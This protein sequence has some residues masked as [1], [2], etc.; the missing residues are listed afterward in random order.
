[1]SLLA[2]PYFSLINVSY[3][4]TYLLYFCNLVCKNI[5]SIII[6]FS[7]AQVWIS[8]KRQ[9]KIWERWHCPSWHLCCPS[10]FAPSCHS[11]CPT[12]ISSFILFPLIQ[13]L[14]F[15]NSIKQ[16]C[17]LN[18]FILCLKQIERTENSVKILNFYILLNKVLNSH[19]SEA[20]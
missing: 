17:I 13:Y 5:E 8:M 9:I 20:V 6:Y 1:M 19:C 3:S 18:I 15:S 11:L 4:L 7:F 10:F 16:K 14:K 12:S 2:L